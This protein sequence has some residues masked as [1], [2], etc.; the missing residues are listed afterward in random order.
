MAFTVGLTG[1]IASGK[2]AVS[3][4]FAALGVPVID[5]D[6]IAREVVAPGAPALREVIT[7]FGEDVVDGDGRL[8]RRKLREII[9]SDA[10]KQDLP[11][12]RRFA[13]RRKSASRTSTRPTASW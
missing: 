5:T 8:R 1:G 3:D 4:R 2:S 10:E 12:T 6:L 13:R 9:F 11:C 7:A